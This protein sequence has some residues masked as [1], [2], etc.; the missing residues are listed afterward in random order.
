MTH[1]K[2][3][4]SRNRIHKAMARHGGRRPLFMRMNQATETPESEIIREANKVMESA[5]A[6]TPKHWAKRDVVKSIKD[7]LKRRIFNRK[8][9]GA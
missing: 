9:G 2:Y 8:T 5:E 6:E 7:V 1:K 4:R 3:S